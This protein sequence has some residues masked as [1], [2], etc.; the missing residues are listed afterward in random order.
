M[1]K[2]PIFYLIVGFLIMLLVATACQ[3]RQ[4][5]VPPDEL[6]PSGVTESA[7]QES[8]EPEQAGGEP[9]PET[10]GPSSGSNVP[11]DIPIPDGVY[12]MQAARNGG[13]IQ[14]KIDGDIEDV[15]NFYTEEFPAHGWEQGRSPDTV[16]G[17]MGSLLRQKENGDRLSISMQKNQLG[18]FVVVTITLS[19]AQ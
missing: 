12:D 18:G 1:R 19:R 11:E 10:E 6:E 5:P 3:P 7:P 4:R 14:F 15:V 13:Y 17:S 9:A 16:V 2:Q 8:Q